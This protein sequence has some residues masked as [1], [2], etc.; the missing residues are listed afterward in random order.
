MNLTNIKMKLCGRPANITWP[1]HS[2]WMVFISYPVSCCLSSD[3]RLHR[4]M[5]LGL[6]WTYCLLWFCQVVLLKVMLLLFLIRP[7]QTKVS[8]LPSVEISIG[9]RSDLQN[10]LS[11]FLT[12]KEQNLPLLRICKNM[13]LTGP[14]QL[15]KKNKYKESDFLCSHTTKNEQCCAVL[16]N[17]AHQSELAMAPGS[18]NWRIAKLQVYLMLTNVML[19]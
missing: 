9:G 6:C 19:M 18:Q 10:H 17:L 5:A 8:D 4:S 15:R 16:E 12:R 14:C 7:L 1:Q 3:H 13:D 11:V 2:D